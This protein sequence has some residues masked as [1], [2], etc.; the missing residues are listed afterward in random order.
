MTRLLVTALLVSG[1]ILASIARSPAYAQTGTPVQCGTTVQGE[2]TRNKEQQDYIVTVKPGYKINVIG[3]ALGDTLQFR[4]VFFGPTGVQILQQKDLVSN[5]AFKSGVLSA[6][7]TYTISVYNYR[8]YD[9]GVGV[10]NLS[11]ECIDENGRSVKSGATAAPVATDVPVSTAPAAT[12][13]PRATVAPTATPAFSGTGFPGVP[14]VDFADVARVAL[15]LD[16]PVSGAISPRNNEILGFTFDAKSNSTLDLSFRRES[17]NLNLG[18]VVLSS[19]NKV[20]FQ[21]SLV[22]SSALSTTLTLPTQGQYTIGIFRV[23]LVEPTKPSATAFELQ[24]R[25]RGR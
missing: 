15:R 3:G 6:R 10:Y 18:L 16:R 2:F 5:P 20:Y 8:V 24:A 25:L 11:V 7:G 17:G 14:P 19:D 22:T 1:L 23:S 4:F 21:T 9:G 13:A 12:A